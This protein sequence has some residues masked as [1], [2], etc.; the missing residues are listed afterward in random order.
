MKFF[1]KRDQSILFLCINMLYVIKYHLI[2][3][4]GLCALMTNHEILKDDELMINI[5]F[6]TLISIGTFHNIAG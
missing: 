2:T 4:I 6:Q 1:F 3:N 5:L